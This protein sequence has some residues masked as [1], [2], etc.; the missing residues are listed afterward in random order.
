MDANKVHDT[1]RKYILVDGYPFVVDLKNSHGC[2]LVD[3]RNGNELLDCYSMHAAMPIS[4][5]HP[6]LKERRQRL[7]DVAE[8]NPSNSDC[9]TEPYAEFVEAFAKFTPD[10]C[11]YFF[12]SGGTLGV[13][14]ALK[15]AFDWKAKKLKLFDDVQSNSMDIIHFTNAFDGR[16]LGSLSITNTDPSKTQWFPKFN[17]SRTACPSKDLFPEVDIEI[18]EAMVLNDIE[19]TLKKNQ[20]AAVLLEP[21]FSEGGDLY[22]RKEFMQGLRRLTNQYETL[23][24]LDEVQTGVGL[25]GRDWCYQHFDIIP[26]LM[27][28]GKKTQVSGFCST[29]RIDEIPNNVFNVSSRINST[30]GGNLVDMTRATIFLEIIKEDNLTQNAADVGSYFLEELNNLNL[31]NARG[32]GLILAFDLE[33]REKRDEFFNKLLDKMVC[34][35]C[36]EKSIRFRP[37]LDFQREHVDIATKIIKDLL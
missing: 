17:W 11:H 33:S 13:E 27:V 34:L 31:K 12:I 25:S 36:G 37:H 7:W 20:V 2:W 21:I 26:D 23:L 18:L 16:S 8:Y 30:F 35:K 32:R 3:K 19:N 14:N 29:K 9:Y 6:K 10:F 4:W 24:I 28:F 22:I 1:L 15:A 5:N